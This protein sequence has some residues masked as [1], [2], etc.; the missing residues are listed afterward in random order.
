MVQR[1]EIT[2]RASSTGKLEIVWRLIVRKINFYFADGGGP[3]GEL[4]TVR[5]KCIIL[6]VETDNENIH[7]MQENYFSWLWGPDR[8]KE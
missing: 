7:Y 8:I 6:T 3:V 5:V 2:V 1:Q 4:A